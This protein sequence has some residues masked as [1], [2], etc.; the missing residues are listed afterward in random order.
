VLAAADGSDIGPADT[1]APTLVFQQSAR[2]R[3]ERKE[4]PFPAA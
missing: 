2:R 1:G 3:V 4:L